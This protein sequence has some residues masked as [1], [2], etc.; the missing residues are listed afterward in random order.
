MSEKISVL[1]LI[2]V[3]VRLGAGFV[4]DTILKTLLQC[5]LTPTVAVKSKAKPI[6][7]LYIISVFLPGNLMC[8]FSSNV[9]CPLNLEVYVLGSFLKLLFDLLSVYLCRITI[10]VQILDRLMVL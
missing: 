9:L 1:P 2:L 7:F 6:D 4:L 8:L 5:Q 10:T 3:V